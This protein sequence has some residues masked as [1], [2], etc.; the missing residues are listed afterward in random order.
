MVDS[1]LE[2]L[3]GLNLELEFLNLV[4]LESVL[5]EKI[6]FFL[7]GFDSAF[8]LQSNHIDIVFECGNFLRENNLGV[9]I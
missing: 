2:L 1:E 7:S 9:I 8:T 3:G 6:S 5:L 4:L